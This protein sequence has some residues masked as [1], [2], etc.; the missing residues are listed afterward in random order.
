MT[1]L[2]PT[3]GTRGRHLLRAGVLLLVCAL[4]GA[5]DVLNNSFAMMAARLASFP[6][7]EEHVTKDRAALV[8]AAHPS[9]KGTIRPV[10]PK[11]DRHRGRSG[12]F[13]A[14]PSSPTSRGH[15]CL[16]GAGIFQLC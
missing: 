3:T 1:Q 13:A 9:R 8:A 12:E 11:A 4:G 2:R 5:Y 6:E 7:E 15:R 14:A 16:T 10:S